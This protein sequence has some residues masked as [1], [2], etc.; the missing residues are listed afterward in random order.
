MT[1]IRSVHADEIGTIAAIHVQSWQ[2]AYRGIMPDDLLAEQ[3]ITD[4]D[5]MWRETLSKGSGELLVGID[6]STEI[7]GFTFL[8]RAQDS[9]SDKPYDG[10]VSALHIRPDRKRQEIGSGLLQA[11]FD[12]LR[13]MGCRSA[14]IWTLEDLTPSRRFYERHGGT[15]VKSK[16]GDFSGNKI[17]EV[18][19]GWEDL[20]NGV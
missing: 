10:R 7:M 14:I 2:T 18:A 12:C 3:N 9:P 4:R 6:D 19:Y 17:A 8:A 11:A 20:D 1:T 16:L 5:K 15:I 13:I